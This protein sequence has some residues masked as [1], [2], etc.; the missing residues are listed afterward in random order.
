MATRKTRT[1]TWRFESPVRKI[2]PVLAD[3]GRFNEA[4]GLPKHEIVEIPQDDGAML[5]VGRVKKGP[6]TIEWDDG[7][8]N[9]VSERWF[10]H[11]RRFRNGPLKF[12]GATL[13][14][15]PEATGCRGE[16]TVTVE[17]ANWLGRLAIATWFFPSTGRMFA[18]LARNADEFAMG[19]R[20]TE[21]DS[22]PPRLADGA[23]ERVTRLVAEIEAT[24]HNHGLARRLADYVLTRQEIEVSSIRPLKLARLWRVPER[25]AIEVC[26]EA[27]KRGLLSM[28]WDLLCPR[29]QVGKAATLAMD[30][31]P[32]GA[33][34]GSCNIDY[35]REYARNIEVVFYPA[36]A[37]R[38]VAGGDYCLFGPMS[39]PHIKIHLT[40]AP[41][42]R[43]EVE[44]G[45]DPGN[46]RLRTLEAGG[47]ATIEWADGGFPEVIADGTTIVA[48]P[49]S[50]P[51][52][53]ILH[54]RSPK[55]RTLIVEERIWR[56]DA[57]T[58]DRAIALQAFRDLFSTEVLRPG[59]DI[60]IEAVTLM[61]TDFK[62]ST[63]LYNR[64]GDPQAY[65]LVR[66]HYAIIGRAVRDNNGTV[67]KTIGDAVMG[68]F[69]DPADALKAAIR[70]QADLAAYNRTSGKDPITIKLGLHLGRCI[71]VTLNG[72]LDYYGAAANKAARL[73]GQSLGGD[74]VIS[75]D[76]AKDPGL[77]EILAEFSPV[78]GRAALKGFATDAVFFRLTAE[79]LEAKRRVK[80]TAGDHAPR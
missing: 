21:F 67:V 80:N 50:P 2:W 75:D 65:A 31:L 45:L 30:E 57:L 42:E 34:C 62:G 54:N 38:L 32:T 19:R 20:E 23:A 25:D 44:I 39:T 40:L 53:V 29:C 51:G 46:Y 52:R 37:I 59:D 64:I 33:H 55:T 5:F 35:G 60:A 72:R 3:T 36:P 14:F 43:R 6:F 10:R 22:P 76:F 24:P 74:I 13:T 1:W 17:A 12:L 66:E 78:E 49:P 56:R 9:W 69:A 8:A 11:D 71:A 77:T 79:E 47:E 26:L 70:M 18:R 41:G 48:G 27:A 15:F 58:A 4:A 73:E 7:P 28:R 63:A 16:Y 61:F 68:A